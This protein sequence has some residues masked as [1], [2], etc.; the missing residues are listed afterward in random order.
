MSYTVALFGEAE[1][2]EFRTAYFCQTL[3]QLAE[4]LGEPPKESQGLHY[5]VQSLLYRRNLIFFRVREEGF[6]RQDY[7]LGLRFLED[8]QFVS[9]LTAICMPGVGDYSIIEAS[10]A[11]CYAHNSFFIH[12]E[13]DLY[14]YLTDR[15]PGFDT[16]F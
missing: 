1:K 15:E 9:D 10:E 6:S 7:L 14:D 13:A 16:G 4:N 11:V 12:N 3:Y 2:G 8:S 5:A